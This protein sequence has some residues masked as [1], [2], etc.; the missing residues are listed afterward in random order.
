MA[1]AVIVPALALPLYCDPASRSISARIVS[2]DGV[3][4]VTETIR[5]WRETPRATIG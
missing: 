2:L 5:F 4:A 3:K 1:V